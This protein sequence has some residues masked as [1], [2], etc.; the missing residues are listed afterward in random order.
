MHRRD[1]V[2][3]ACTIEYGRQLAWVL[4][5]T[6]LNAKHGLTAVH[7]FIKGWSHQVHSIQN[8]A[9]FGQ[10]NMTNSY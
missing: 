1:I 9:T 4:I 3:H 6:K 7:Y 10:L 5:H 2:M 8:T